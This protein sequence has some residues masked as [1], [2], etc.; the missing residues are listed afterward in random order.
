M[1]HDQYPTGFGEVFNL[2]ER[3]HLV[4]VNHFRN[5]DGTLNQKSMSAFSN[6]VYKEHTARVN[7]VSMS[8]SMSLYLNTLIKSSD[9]LTPPERD[10]AGKFFFGTEYSNAYFSALLHT[11]L[12]NRDKKTGWSCRVAA[13]YVE[14]CILSSL[15]ALDEKKEVFESTIIDLCC[16]YP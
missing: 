7:P 8:K 6:K 3:T 16:K 13:E 10:L 11:C 2:L 1:T 5:T 4:I 14:R 12:F 15:V 9:Y